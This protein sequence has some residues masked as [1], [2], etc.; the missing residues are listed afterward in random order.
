MP[1]LNH[2]IQSTNENNQ[3]PPKPKLSRAEQARINGAKS[4]GPKTPQ[5]KGRSCMNA[6]KHGKYAKLT[7]ALECEDRQGFLEMESLYNERYQPADQIEAQLVSE[8]ATIDWRIN[9]SIA[10][11][12]RTFD[13]QV[14]REYPIDA[15]EAFT[16]SRLATAV[17]KLASNSPVLETIARRES[18]L[19]R[20][21]QII[22]ETLFRLR[23]LQPRPDRA[24]IPNDS[25][26]IDP[27]TI[28]DS[29]PPGPE[30][31]Q[32]SNPNEPA[33]PE[34]IPRAA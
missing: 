4:R 5:G 2:I 11:E 8:L 24:Q 29:I 21:R 30:T 34:D 26:Y 17:Q 22:L 6:M 14:R 25:D 18:S 27:E 7:A 3:P 33:P 1:D 16:L 28:P 31:N 13:L 23:Q 32:Q 9:R 12:T 10:M 20:N 19:V 15:F